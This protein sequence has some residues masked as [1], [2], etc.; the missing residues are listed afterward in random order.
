MHYTELIDKLLRELSYRVGI[1]NLKDKTHQSAISEILS[2]W[3]EYDA[4]QRIFEFL[5]EKDDEKTSEDKKYKN[6]GGSGY[7]KAQDYA[8]W[9]A[10]PKGDFEKFTKEGPGVYKPM[11]TDGDNGEEKEEKELGK[12][13]KDK[14]YQGKVKK[15]KETQDKLD[16]EEKLKSSNSSELEKTP[17][18]D[19]N[20]V[21]PQ[22]GKVSDV[23]DEFSDGK[24]KQL[25]LEYGTK[26]KEKFTPAP[27]NA[28]SMLGEIMSGE[29][30]SHLDENPNLTSDELA[31]KMYD[32]VENTTLGRE[33]G[34]NSKPMVRGKYEGL[35]KDLYNKC[36]SFA[37]ASLTKYKENQRGIENLVS[38]NKM[39]KP[40]KVR[41]FYGHETSI[42]QQVNL[43]N[44]CNGPIYTKEGI[45]VPRE[46]IIDLI[47]K[48][49]GGD[50]P[51]DTSTITV[52]SNG[53]AMV[54]F[55]SDKISTSDIQANSTPNKEA[56]VAIEIVD[57]T[58]IPDIIKEDVKRTIQ[59]GNRKLQEK[60]KELKSAANEPALQM[61][62]GD[63]SKILGGAKKDV[64]RDNNPQKDKTST[65]IEKSLTSRGKTHPNI[66]SYLPE[67]D[68]PHTEEQ[69]FKAYLEYMGDDDKETE[70]TGDQVT[71]LFR[72]GAQQ[73]YD[74]SKDLSRIRMESLETQR[75]TH[76]KLNEK[77]HTLPS[78]KIIPVGDYIEGQNLI[79]KLHL[80]VMDGEKNEKGVGKYPGLFNLNMGG[81]LVEGD[82]LKDCI[83][84]DGTDDFIESF[85]VGVPGDGEEVTRNTKTNAVTGRNIFVFAVTKDGKRIPVAYKTQRSKA[86]QSGK[87]NTTYQWDNGIQDCFKSN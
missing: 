30:F 10:D 42:A 81:T 17:A 41:N 14:S 19:E 56:E 43:I 9:K 75:E 62:Q 60:E 54:T 82:Q 57:K 22:V 76:K 8:K 29:G 38:G 70:P 7:V 16:N 69:K 87:L 83:G 71:L 77:N 80:N 53:R 40:V 27:G 11:E 55:H 47:E 31:K 84:V 78:G 68:E 23:D 13:L 39:T 25:A 72:V 20:K 4:K 51:S 85:E 3:G 74:I 18:F 2:E 26:N 44:K 65:K 66:V 35:K 32:Q 52:D 28:G 63:V 79:E 86:G 45:E 6:T 67:Q 21:S 73:G 48:S 12:S 37:K 24:I 46:V 50:N 58:D 15:E 49:G 33:N 34:G 64:D 61:A 1:P 36:E 5:T 59:D